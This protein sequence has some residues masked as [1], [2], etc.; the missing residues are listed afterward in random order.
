[1]PANGHD[2]MNPPAGSEL[3]GNT[4]WPGVFSFG[5]AEIHPNIFVNIISHIILVGGHDINPVKRWLF[6]EETSVQALTP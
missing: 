4:I 3:V 2:K 1:M 6:Y 5:A